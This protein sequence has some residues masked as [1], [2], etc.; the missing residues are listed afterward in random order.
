ML[1]YAFPPISTLLIKLW[2]LKFCS[3]LAPY[4][5]SVGQVS[6]PFY[7]PGHGF[8]ICRLS[9][10]PDNNVMSQISW[11]FRQTCWG[12]NTITDSPWPG[13]L[14]QLVTL[15]VHPSV[16]SLSFLVIILKRDWLISQNANNLQL[17]RRTW[18]LLTIVPSKWKIYS[19][20]WRSRGCLLNTVL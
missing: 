12:V 20:K 10:P 5:H 6:I 16:I 8:E 14:I 15:L 11:F 7:N 13:F 3:L 2:A 17:G 4:I 1:I 9:G 19:D 18:H